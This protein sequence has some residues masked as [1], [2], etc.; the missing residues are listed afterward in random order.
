[1]SSATE[2][3]HYL[4][5]QVAH[6]VKGYSVQCAKNRLKSHKKQIFLAI[7]VFSVGLLCWGLFKQSKSR[8]RKHKAALW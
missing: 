4:E 1:M 6:P 8:K 7:L 2:I 5:E 3:K